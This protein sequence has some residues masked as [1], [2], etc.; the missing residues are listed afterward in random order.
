VV[1]GAALVRALGLAGLAA[2][3]AGGAAGSAGAETPGG[4]VR[5]AASS[6]AP[7]SAP[8]S[9][10]STGQSPA[11]PESTSQAPASPGTTNPSSTSPGSATQPPASP[12]T[13][14][15]S[16]A[17]AAAAAGEPFVLTVEG[18]PERVFVQQAVELVVRVAY[19]EAWLR[20]AAVPL[21]Q[22]RLDLPFH[23]VVPWL[24]GAEDRAVEL[25][26]PPGGATTRR[27][28][29]GDRVVPMVVGPAR[30]VGGR[31]LAQLELRCRWLPLAA[32]AS[33]I[34]PVQVRYA[35]ATQFT[36][37]FLSGRQPV[38]RRE[39]TAVSASHELRVQ[40]LPPEPPAG[41]TGAV[42]E[43]SVRA[44]ATWTR[45]P[46]GRRSWSCSRSRGTATSS[47]SRRRPRRAST[48]S[49]CRA[50][51]SPSGARR[52]GS[53]STC[54]RSARARPRSRRCRSSRSRRVLAAT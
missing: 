39:A 30:D 17:T 5:P 3:V 33:P 18:V 38:D 19:D 7:T 52:A 45:S 16:P 23:V 35:F 20:S 37:H 9:P 44:T 36:E 24:Q 32:G 21:F 28:A 4:A 51:P 53:G 48:A 42:G 41:F 8:A 50:S 27:V 15:Q 34:A 2:L 40:P 29:V 12:A 10:A 13:T 26:P 1:I 11:S 43:F 22:Q 31:T 47:A 49:T 54:W 6:P 25:L 14:G 46:W